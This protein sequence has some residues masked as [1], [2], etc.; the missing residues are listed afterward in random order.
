MPTYSKIT[1]YFLFL[2]TTAHAQE[3][4]VTD[5]KGTIKI[6][7]NNQVTT[8]TAV[9][10]GSVIGD[11]WFDT[12]APNIIP[13]I[14]D[15]SLVWKI[16]DQDK[17]STSATAPPI[18][19]IGDIW[20]DTSV[21]PNILNI[22]DGNTWISINDQFWSLQGN[23]GT[24]AATDFIGTV[25]DVRMQFRSNNTPI[26]ELGKR[27]TLGLTQDS[28]D[29]TDPNQSLV[30]LKGSNGVSA[31]Q[32]EATNAS[33]YKPM[34]FTTNNGSF[35]L[36][37]SSGETDLFEIGS[38]GP[39][40]E[41]RLEFII[42]DDGNEPIIFKRFDY[43][44]GQFY[45]ELFR[46]Q[47]SNLTAEAKTRFG[48]N[49][50]PSPI[51]VDPTYAVSQSTLNIANSTFQVNGSIST[52]ILKLESAG[53]FTLTED[54]Y[55]III[56][57]NS[58]IILPAANSCTG[59]TYIIKNISG[60]TKTTSI[61]Y[62]NN[63]NINSNLI[64]NNATIHL[65][66]DGTDWTAT[67]TIHT[68][69]TITNTAA[70]GNKIAD[71]TNEN[72]DSVAINETVTSLTQDNTPTTTNTAATGEIT[73]SDEN[74]NTTGK[75]QVVSADV[76]NKIAVGN[77]GGA[78]SNA[79]SLFSVTTTAAIADVPFDPT[80]QQADNAEWIDMNSA[81]PTTTISVKTGDIIDVRVQISEQFSNYNDMGD[82]IRLYVN[83]PSLIGS[84]TMIETLIAGGDNTF[85]VAAASLNQL[86]TVTG[87][88][89]LTI[90]IQVQYSDNSQR[91][92]STN[93]SG[94][95]GLQVI[96]YR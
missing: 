31:L 89:S 62:K 71:Y 28:P 65:Q 82:V 9:P 30:Y 48:I 80:S 15:N 4:R 45:K 32:F 74:S 13:K 92:Y 6:V 42:G 1:I 11:V 23:T 73:F 33:F 36:K 64:N 25:D 77:D 50:N 49:I 96:I 52:G 26:L 60:S 41:G 88:G 63:L 51:S 67:S 29:Y 37:G 90:G 81:L 5:N 75:A 22:W 55:T 70:S 38:A 34:F 7:Q 19:N 79:R 78:F 18:R 61:N 54:H 87:D 76:G 53:N 57:S 66:S 40:N 24:D 8:G 69:T 59:R 58:N 94:L 85:E 95:G 3:I 12:T 14:Y 39:S 27:E 68:I 2:I 10:T 17:V 83:T 46:V 86:F 91:T 72:G 93:R 35:R 47:G 44:N 21:T 56:S 43:R 84:P 16:I 20:L